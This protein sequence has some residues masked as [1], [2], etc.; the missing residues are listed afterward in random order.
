[1]TLLRD[2]MRESF[3][4]YAERLKRRRLRTLF[5][6]IQAAQ[7]RDCTICRYSVRGILNGWTTEPIPHVCTRWRT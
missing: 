1:M 7:R 4:D 3:R 5:Q 6:Q 2:S